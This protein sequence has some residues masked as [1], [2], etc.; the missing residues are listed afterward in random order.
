MSIHEQGVAAAGKVIE[1]GDIVPVAKRVHHH[2]DG[3]LRFRRTTGVVN[4]G[5]QETLD[6]LFKRVSVKCN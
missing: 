4:V 6:T 1:V 3:A 2:P 5:D